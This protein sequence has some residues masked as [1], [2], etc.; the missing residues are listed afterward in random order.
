MEVKVYPKSFVR[1]IDQ[2]EQE[3]FRCPMDQRDKAFQFAKQMESL[4][5]EVSIQEPSSIET[6]ATSLGVNSKGREKIK[7]AINHEIKEH[8]I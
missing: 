6:L 3:L 1:V 2:T 7:E 5:V 4:G 8:G